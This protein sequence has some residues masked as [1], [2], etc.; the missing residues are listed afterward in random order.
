M[1]NDAATT[2]FMSDMEKTPYSYLSQPPA[3]M[4]MPRPRHCSMKSKN[5]D[6]EQVMSSHTQKFYDFVRRM[7]AQNSQMTSAYD[8]ESIQR[9]KKKMVVYEH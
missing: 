2:A 1:A 3:N 8:L 7:N 5:G 6:S 4:S 9:P